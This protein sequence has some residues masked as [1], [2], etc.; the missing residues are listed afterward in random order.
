MSFEPTIIVTG[1]ASGIGSAIVRRIAK[2]GVRLLLHTGRNAE[3]LKAVGQEATSLG[4]EVRLEIGD[5]CDPAVPS[6]LVERAK[7]AFGRVDQI[8]SNAG[9]AQKAR[10]ETLNGDDLN[11]AFAL[12]PIAFFHLT[13]AALANLR[14][15]EQG[16]IVAISSFVAHSFGTNEMHFP[17]TGAAKAALEALAKSLAVQLAP[18]SVT[19]NCVAPGFVRKDASGHAAT[20]RSAMESAQRITPNGRLGEPD[21]IAE[22]VAFLLSPGA[23]H[24]TGQT[25][26]VDGGLLLP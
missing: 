24:I 12:S 16:R 10:F 18:D 2:P 22:I 13:K 9:R 3:G 23:R 7:T 21:D 14:A 4:S 15:S 17:A 11:V 1:A 19:V 8:V 6:R 5:L 25:M 26:H 20:S